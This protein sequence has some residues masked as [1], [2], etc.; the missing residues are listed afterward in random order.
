MHKHT[1][2]YINISPK[3]VK[4]L[5]NKI[6]IKLYNRY[7]L[8]SVLINFSKDM[9]PEEE[10]GCSASKEGLLQT[11]LVVVYLLVSNI[12][13]NFFLFQFLYRQLQY[14]AIWGTDIP[15]NY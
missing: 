15:E 12:F 9:C 5:S 4:H 13:Q 1:I 2:K 11:A 3:C 7:T 14:L 10:D 8:A 6:L